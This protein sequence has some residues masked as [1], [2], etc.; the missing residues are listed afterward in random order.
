MDE[1]HSGEFRHEGLMVSSQIFKDEREGEGGS[2][3]RGCPLRLA[4]ERAFVPKV[5]EL[6]LFVAMAVKIVSKYPVT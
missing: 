6:G 2:L 5:M 1:L 4:K 3:S